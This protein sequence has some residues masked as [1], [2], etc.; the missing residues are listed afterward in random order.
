MMWTFVSF[1]KIINI[2]IILYIYF[3]KAFLFHILSNFVVFI[4]H[5]LDIILFI[6]LIY[7]LIIFRYECVSST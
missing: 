3:F 7:Y 2:Y 5:F 4:P 6:I 1:F